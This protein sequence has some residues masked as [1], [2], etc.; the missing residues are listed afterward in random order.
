MKHLKTAI[1]LYYQT[2]INL[3]KSLLE[4]DL[5][6][7]H[8]IKSCYKYII[9][10]K[11]LFVFKFK[12]NFF[13]N[14]AIHN[15]LGSLRCFQSGIDLSVT[16][17]SMTS[18]Y[19]LFLFYTKHLLQLEQKPSDRNQWILF[20]CKVLKKKSIFAMYIAYMCIL[21]FHFFKML[22]PHYQRAARKKK[23]DNYQ[24]IKKS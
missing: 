24:N 15:S 14:L 18:M 5:I 6:L 20:V 3:E 16:T 9:T 1:S 21:L 10:K 23:V 4:R 17:N 22:K 2:N 12:I 11:A 13:E 19:L 7:I 8:L